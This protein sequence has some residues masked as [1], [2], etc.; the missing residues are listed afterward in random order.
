M[1][2]QRPDKKKLNQYNSTQQSIYLYDQEFHLLKVLDERTTS[3][4][5]KYCKSWEKQKIALYLTKQCNGIKTIIAWETKLRTEQG[6][7]LSKYKHHRD[8]YPATVDGRLQRDDNSRWGSKIA[9]KSDGSIRISMENV[10][11]ISSD[12]NK[13]LK[14]D[15]EKKMAY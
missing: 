12:H 2:L 1:T 10:N 9:Q 4:S 7:E 11:N 8:K 3:V 13:N 5:R 15:S 14:L 6:K